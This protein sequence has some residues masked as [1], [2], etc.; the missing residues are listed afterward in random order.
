MSLKHKR[1]DGARQQGAVE[2]T[3]NVLSA[4]FCRRHQFPCFRLP[5]LMCPAQAPSQD[6]N[7]S[8]CVFPFTSLN[9]ERYYYPLLLLLAM[10]SA[11][12]ATASVLLHAASQQPHAGTW[13][14]CQCRATSEIARRVPMN[15]VSS[16]CTALY[17]HIPDFLSGSHTYGASPTRNTPL[18]TSCPTV[19]L[20]A[21]LEF[22]YLS[23]PGPLHPAM[24]QL[25]PAQ[26]PLTPTP[27]LK[28]QSCENIKHATDSQAW[29][30]KAY[31]WALDLI[32]CKQFT[33]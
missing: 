4:S 25:A 18:G 8:G 33:A 16:H 12:G 20:S 29:K 7:T 24:S 23:S 28:S 31:L 1:R 17:L 26:L 30:T 5:R 11:R 10:I 2:N 27:S 9:L 13:C 3:R 6:I 32:V 21:L 22:L 15:S 14:G 19:C